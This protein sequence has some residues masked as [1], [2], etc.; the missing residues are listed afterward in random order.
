MHRIPPPSCPCADACRDPGRARA[1]ARSVAGLS[2]VIILF[3]IISL[4]D[5]GVTL[6]AESSPPVGRV[7]QGRKIFR[8]GLGADDRFI[9]AEV[10][11]PPVSLR[12]TLMP[13]IGC[14]G[15]Q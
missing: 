14:H 7:V 5:S 6:A 9:T 13:C 4:A 1:C 12:A 3:A 10:G 11:A 15:N 8:N 2:R